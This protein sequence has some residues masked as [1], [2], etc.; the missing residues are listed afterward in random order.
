[1]TDGDSWAVVLWV[2]LWHWLTALLFL[3][4]SLTG[5]YL[6]FAPRGSASGYALANSL[7]DLAGIALAATYL[8]YVA[9][10]LTT[11]HWR[12]FVPDRRGLGQRLRREVAIYL[13]A[14]DP[15]EVADRF[16]PLQ[17]LTYLL[18]VYALLPLLIL[19]GLLYRYYP[20]VPVVA[21]EEV[22]GLGG[23]WP[24]ASVHYLLAIPGIAFLIVHIYM[25][26]FAPGSRAML[27][28]M[29]IGR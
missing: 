21:P 15:A 7:H 6:H 18:V 2:R 26:A 10:A 25:G 11:G 23:L 3:I 29:I 4:L 14:G 5:V 24:L 22:L 20:A 9:G 28:R 13:R 19:S 8:A 17:Q 16:K 27:K 12:H 1:M